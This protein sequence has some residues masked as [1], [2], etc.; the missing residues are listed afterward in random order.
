MIYIF[1]FI[2]SLLFISIALYFRKKNKILFLIFSAIGL[3]VPCLLAA[4]RDNS[5][6]TDVNIYIYPLFKS[7]KNYES[8]S[9][10][11]L[12]K[13]SSIDD[14]LYLLN[15]FL[16]A[17]LS[18]EAFLLYFMNEA[19]VIVPL[20]IALLK[21]N[22]RN[23]SVVIGM[24]IFFM[25]FYNQTF[26]MARQSIAIS[27]ALLSLAYM[28]NS[29][30]KKSIFTNIIACLFHKSAIVNFLILVYYKLIYK[31]KKMG[32]NTKKLIKYSILIVVTIIV[33][34]LPQIMSILASLNIFADKFNNML[35]NSVRGEIVLTNT[36]FY[37]FIWLFIVINSKNNNTEIQD[38]DF[39]KF[40]SLLSVIILHMG[41]SIKFSDRIG[42]YG[43]YAV[44]FFLLPRLIPKNAKHMKKMELL[45]VNII[46]VIFIV[47]WVFWIIIQRYHETYPYIFFMQ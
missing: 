21:I 35:Q 24:F 11:C 28:I 15:T 31:N 25:F 1:T 14:I 22:D 7:A 12:Y 27:F 45:N 8:F 17:K 3:G 42:Y 46:M 47:Y 33:V 43:F 26:N 2:I 18:N 39:F 19:L 16:C 41:V 10:F 13:K 6:G 4:L 34:A 29:H 44:L 20:Y 30:T 37:I 32:S 9:A 36:V 40:L 23:N 5:I 38:Y